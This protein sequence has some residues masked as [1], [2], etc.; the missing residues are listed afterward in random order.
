[1]VGG[2]FIVIVNEEKL[3]GLPFTQHEAYNFT[4]YINNCGLSEVKLTGSKYTWWNGRIEEDCMLKR[5]DRIMGNSTF[6]NTFP[7][8][9][10]SHLIR[11]G[12]DHASIQIICRTEEK[13]I[14]RPFRFLNFWTKH[15]QFKEVVQANWK[16][17]IMGNPFM[18]FHAKLKNV[19]KALIKWSRYMFVNIFQH[20]PTIEDIIKTKEA[21]FEIRSSAENRMEL[22]RM[23]AELKKFLRFEEEF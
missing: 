8:S 1:M 4:Q 2:D 10:V 21:Q 20:I 17:D 22:N 9:E 13:N 5:L 7:S 19:K 6:M 15:H 14:I 12:S 3:G 23:E 18:I 16:T 11:Q